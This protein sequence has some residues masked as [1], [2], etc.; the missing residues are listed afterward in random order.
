[1]DFLTLW[2]KMYKTGEKHFHPTMVSRS[3]S[4]I[5][6]GNWERSTLPTFLSPNNKNKQQ[7][8]LFL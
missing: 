2:L 7:E 3:D 6:N 1:M 8:H 4:H 5:R